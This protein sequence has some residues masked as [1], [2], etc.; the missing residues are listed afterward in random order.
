MPWNSIAYVSSAITLVAFL[1]AIAAW[2]Y[3]NSLLRTQNLIDKAPKDKK[4][5]LIAQTLESFNP[6][7]EELLKKLTKDQLHVLAMRQLQD[8][9]TK[10]KIR[11]IVVTIIAVLTAAV[12]IYALSTQAGKTDVPGSTPTATPT[13]SQ[14]VNPAVK[15]TQTNELIQIIKLII[16]TGGDDK[17]EFNTGQITISKGDE[18]LAQEKIGGELWAARSVKVFNLKLKSAVSLAECSQLVL[19]I[20]KNG[21]N[22]WEGSIE[23]RAVTDKQKNVP[24]TPLNRSFDFAGGTSSL[25]NGLT[26]E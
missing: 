21:S 2:V 5:Q 9:A 7:H 17:D 14:T 16:T 20:T 23:V 12:S 19:E 26:C 11:A 3:R 13:V 24:L 22:Q 8:N 6:N 15:G 18:I 10:F 1:A 4:A 25:R